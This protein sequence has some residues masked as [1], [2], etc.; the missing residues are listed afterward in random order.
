MPFGVGLTPVALETLGS[1]YAPLSTDFPGISGRSGVSCVHRKTFMQWIRLAP[2]ID[3]IAHEESLVLK[4]DFVALR[5]EGA[6]AVMVGQRV[7]PFLDEWRR[8]DD[9]CSHL[10]DYNPVAI[11]SLAEQLVSAG[12]LSASD[13]GPSGPAD[14]SPW[15]S[16][17]EVLGVPVG[18]ALARLRGLRV[19]IFGLEH[20]GGQIAL[21]LAQ[22]GVGT[23]ALA[24]PGPIRTGDLVSLPLIGEPGPKSNRQEAI[25]QFLATRSFRPAV[26]MF[27]GETLGRE[28]VREIVA[29]SDFAVGTF[30]RAFGAC[31]HWINTACLETG[32]PAVYCD[33]QGIRAYVGPVVF[34]GE[35]ACYMCWRM[36]YL[37]TRDNFAE[38][39]AYESAMD[40][41]KA[42]QASSRPL[43]PPLV[44]WAASLASLEI[45]KIA[46]GLAVPRTANRV[47][48]LDGLDLTMQEHRFLHRPDCPACE[49]IVQAV[50]RGESR[51]DT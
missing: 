14:D 17:L 51:A 18:D 27:Q 28:E 15:H 8:I 47:L 34:P 43:F 35:T 21:Q 3:S 13:T 48:E 24:D 2:G 7:I 44:G 4:S 29:A 45:L 33:L 6:S 40:K 20:I 36:R 46:L 11:R 37:A 39:M 22:L 9:L 25:A 10:S 23:F 1:P 19:A 42:P 50:K 38:A 5:L 41:R 32:I 16:L 26:R 12:V 31:H 30:D 49:G